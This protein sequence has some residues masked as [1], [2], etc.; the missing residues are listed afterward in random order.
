MIGMTKSRT[1][2]WGD[3]AGRL[4]APPYPPEYPTKCPS[5]R[6]EE[7]HSMKHNKINTE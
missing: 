3:R 6:S 2:N 5:E 1:K 7:S 4:A